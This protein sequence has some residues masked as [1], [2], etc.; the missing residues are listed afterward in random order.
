V[1]VKKIDDMFSGVDRI[2]VCDG[3]T[4]GRRSPH[5]AYASRGKNCARG[6]VLLKLTTD[7]HEA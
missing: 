6:I 2:P 3:R 1:M 7:R 5:Y 4:D